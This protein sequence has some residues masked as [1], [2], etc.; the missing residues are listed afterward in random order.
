RFLQLVDHPHADL[1]VPETDY[2]FGK[3]IRAQAAGDRKALEQRGRQV[4]TVDLGS[5]AAAGLAT[6]RQAIR[7]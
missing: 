4:L 2:T 7:A 5:D 1:P 3:L 6:L